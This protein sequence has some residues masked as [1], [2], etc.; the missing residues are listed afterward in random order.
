MSS[1]TPSAAELKAAAAKQAAEQA[2]LPYKWT[3]TIAE[4]DVSVPVPPGT[5]ARDLI[6]EIK[7]LSIKVG[8]KGKE[9]ILEVY[10]TIFPAFGAT[11]IKAI[12]TY[13]FKRFWII[14]NNVFLGC[15]SQ[16]CHN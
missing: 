11:D 15:L 6:V 3:Q 14:N 5:R 4:L 8:L 7:S 12:L 16:A 13:G 9:P 10:L 1:D 2:A